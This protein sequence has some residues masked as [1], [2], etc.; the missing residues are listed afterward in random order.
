VVILKGALKVG[1]RI[2]II[3]N[4]HEFIDTVASMQI[5]RQEIKSAASGQEVAIKI[6]EPVKAGAIV[7][8]A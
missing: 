2:K 1:D 8:R 4:G 5:D 3:R 6:S 7:M